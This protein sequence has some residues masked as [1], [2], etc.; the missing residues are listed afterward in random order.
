MSMNESKAADTE[1]LMIL[2]RQHER[3]VAAVDAGTMVATCETEA[4]H[5]LRVK[6]INDLSGNDG[7]RG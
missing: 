1:E 7:L 4:A 5:Q 3:Y 6:R 2:V